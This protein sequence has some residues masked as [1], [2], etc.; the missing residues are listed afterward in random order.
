[1]NSKDGFADSTSTNAMNRLLYSKKTYEPITKKTWGASDA[2][3]ITERN[4]M[5]AVGKTS[6]S[7]GFVSLSHT[8]GNSVRDAVRRARSGGATVPKKV[9]AKNIGVI[10]NPPDAPYNL[11]Y[12]YGD[13]SVTISFLNGNNHGGAII[14]YAYSYNGTT[15]TDFSPPVTSGPVTLNGLIDGTTYSVYLKAKNIKGYSLPASIRVTPSTIPSAPIIL[16]AS[17]LNS[18]VSIT[19][20]QGSNGGAPITN[21]AY[22]FDDNTYVQF[23][24]AVT[25]SPITIY[26]LTNDTSYLIYLKAVNKNGMSDASDPISSTPTLPYYSTLLTSVSGVIPL[27]QLEAGDTNS[28]TSGYFWYDVGH[29]NTSGY[30]SISYNAGLVG[31][32]ISYDNTENSFTFSSNS[33]IFIPDSVGLHANTTQY[34]SFVVWAY[35]PMEQVGKGLFSKMYGSN[36]GYDGFTLQFAANRNLSLIMN[37][38][39]KNDYFTT[40]ANNVYSLNR[41][42]MFTCVVCFGGGSSNPS[43]I[44]VDTTNVGSGNSYETGIGYQTAPIIVP[45][46]IQN[47][48]TFTYCRV[49]AIYYFDGILTSSN[50]TDIYNATSYNYGF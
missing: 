36:Y 20:T 50:V 46:G 31:G 23:N 10:I 38:T 4:R 39:T 5:T 47:G 14:N 35:I 6:E 3:Q 49:G 2:S 28:Y 42:T 25:S 18:S 48:N 44:Y 21:Y 41:W 37:G 30:T 24:P 43:T 45:S 22:S 40:T 15:Y 1:M 12:T 13:S 29:K 7:T 32:G 26:G 33:F 17:G 11:Q 19:F 34:R 16:T 9:G 8:S 27:F